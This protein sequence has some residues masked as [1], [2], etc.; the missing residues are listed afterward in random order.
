MCAQPALV[1][2][3]PGIFIREKNFH[4]KQHEQF[5]SQLVLVS[6]PPQH[7]SDPPVARHDNLTDDPASLVVVRPGVEA[8]QRL[9]VAA[10]E[11]VTTATVLA[12]E[13]AVIQTVIQLD[14][15]IPIVIYRN[16]V[17][18]V[19]GEPLPS[20][21]RIGRVLVLSVSFGQGGGMDPVDG[22]LLANL[23]DLGVKEEVRVNDGL[24]SRNPHLGVFHLHIHGLILRQF[25]VLGLPLCQCGKLLRLGPD[26]APLMFSKPYPSDPVFEVMD[27][28]NLVTPVSHS[29]DLNAVFWVNLHHAVCLH[30]IHHGFVLMAIHLPQAGTPQICQT[31][32][33]ES[34]NQEHQSQDQSHQLVG[35]KLSLLLFYSFNIFP[36]TLLTAGFN[37]SLHD[38][39]PQEESFRSS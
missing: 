3:W 32:N 17:Q 21:L 9:E 14:S 1:L 23:P 25:S 38:A 34:Q 7:T 16:M 26:V 10:A 31:E 12:A 33:T 13:A 4:P 22:Q 11:A 19:T 29:E 8:A 6:D 30:A 20:H 37:A 35:M 36:Q 2:K 39:S 5:K 27:L 28:K 18:D 15:N 24:L